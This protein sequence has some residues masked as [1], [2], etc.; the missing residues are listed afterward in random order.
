MCA[1]QVLKVGMPTRVRYSELKA[2]LKSHTVQAEQLFANET[3]TALIAAILWA[4]A[5]PSEAFRLGKT[6][7]FFKAG[8]IATLERIL[9]HVRCYIKFCAVPQLFNAHTSY[10]VC[11]KL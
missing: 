1:L 9:R 4:F 7:V 2:V 10:L 5:V 8:Q 3:E 11:S 6:R